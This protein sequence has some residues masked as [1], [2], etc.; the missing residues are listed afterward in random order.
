MYVNWL[1]AKAETTGTFLISRR[2]V[3]T[4]SYLQKQSKIAM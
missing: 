3:D 2:V 1:P 4:N